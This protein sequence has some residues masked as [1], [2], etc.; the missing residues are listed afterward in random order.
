MICVMNFLGEIKML[1][2]QRCCE[3]CNHLQQSAMCYQI[4][5]TQFYVTLMHICP[6]LHQIPH[7]YSQIILFIF[8]TIRHCHAN[9]TFLALFLSFRYR[10]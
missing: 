9:K 6:P 1:I 5:C 3:V 10:F 7:C 2:I 8:K 4:F